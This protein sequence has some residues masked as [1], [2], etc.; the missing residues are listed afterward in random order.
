MEDLSYLQKSISQF[1]DA[2]NRIMEAYGRLEKEFA[3]LNLEL[4]KKNLELEK[5]VGEK[6]DVKSYLHNILES[7]T[8]GVVVI[9]L[10]GNIQTING[11]AEVFLQSSR[12]LLTGRNIRTWLAD[13]CP[14]DGNNLLE[15]EYLAGDLGRRAALNDRILDI[16]GSPL[17]ARSG[18]VLG[19]VLVLV[20]VTK[21]EGFKEIAKRSERLA[22]MGELAANIAHEIRNP[23]GSIELFSS[24]LLKDLVEK[25]NRQRV[26]QVI[27]SVKNMDSKISN[28]LYFAEPNPPRMESLF[29]HDI[30][31]EIISFTEPIIDQADIS[32]AVDLDDSEPLV[33]GDT[34]MLKQ[35]FLNVI[36]NALQAMPAGGRLSIKSRRVNA[37]GEGSRNSFFQEVIIVDTGPGIPADVASRIFDPF[38]S[39]KEGNTGLGL[40]IAHNI[41]SLH[42]GYIHV[43]SKPQQGAEFTVALPV[44]QRKF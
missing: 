43:K 28:L 26:M 15:S 17:R 14:G 16:F 23:L 30:I 2:T 44:L 22:A 19:V 13:I 3:N 41:I 6:E 18:D 11:C 39:T 1:N 5:M 9:D 21:M 42:R 34:E 38:F 35:V 32:L 33:S 12:E 10:Q 7:L 29:L 40:A 8:T 36:L 37:T 24:L 31:E 4:E 27:A 25:K 20:D